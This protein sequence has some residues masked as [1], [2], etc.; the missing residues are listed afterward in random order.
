MTVSF[1]VAAKAVFS[2]LILIMIGFYAAKIGVI[3]KTMSKQLSKMIVSVAQPFMLFR[4]LINV[5]YSKAH[6]ISGL[7]TLGIALLSHAIFA[8]FAFLS[9]HYI[10]N[11]KTERILTEY[12][13]TFAN[14]GFMG[15]PLVEALFGDMGLFRGAF[16]VFAFNLSIWSYGMLLL[17][18]G[19]DKNTDGERISV[20]PLKMFFNHGTVPCMVG[21]LFYILQIKLPLP[22]AQGVTYMNNICTPIVL[23]V[24]GAN[25]SRLPLKKIFLDLQLYFFSFLRLLAA[26]CL[27]A[28]IYHLCGMEDS[29]VIFFCVMAALPSA[30][31][32]VMFAE[33]YD[34]R[35]DYAAKTVGISTLLSMFTIP[36][37]VLLCDLILKI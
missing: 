14:A 7:Q 20:S 16:Y 17:A 1:S 23:L 13:I 4:A 2:L 30:S 37:A 9:A 21:F 34:M 8:L 11:N 12:A 6:L 27:I 18:R 36:V 26:P 25:L 28:L 33:I 5:T 31:M 35:P 29:L 32:S 19:Q 10:R 15:F 3:D 24:I 22:V